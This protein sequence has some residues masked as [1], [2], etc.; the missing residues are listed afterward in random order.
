MGKK[1]AIILIMLLFGIP[2][3]IFGRV[4][5]PPAPESPAP[6]ALQLPFFMFLSALES[7]LFG[8]GI[9]FIIFVPGKI[10]SLPEKYKSRAIACYV[11][12]AWLL[13]SWWPHDNLH[14]HNGM[15]LQGLLYIEYGFH[16]TLII[17]SIIL[18]KNFL[19]LLKEAK[20][21]ALLKETK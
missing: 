5:W 12:F 4:I 20:L 16:F 8:L 15:N 6:T 18:T 2:A 1:I 13:V 19:S 11:C 9:A 10:K 7:L 14:I 17:A 3:F 21:V